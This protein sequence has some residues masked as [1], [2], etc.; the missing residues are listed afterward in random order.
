MAVSSRETGSIQPVK[1]VSNNM[2][3]MV[4]PATGA[5]HFGQIRNFD[6]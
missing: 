2:L 4:L 6:P 1:R 3:E 5:I